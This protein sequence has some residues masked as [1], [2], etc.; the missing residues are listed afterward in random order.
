MRTF[1]RCPSTAAQIPFDFPDDRQTVL[2]RW[3]DSLSA[4]CPGCGKIHAARYRDLY[5]EGVLSGI[6]GGHLHLL[7]PSL[8]AA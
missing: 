2:T 7:H 8:K 1:V 3:G 6:A 5:V 4:K